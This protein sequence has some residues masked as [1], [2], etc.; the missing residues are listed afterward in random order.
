VSHRRLETIRGQDQEKEAGGA[1]YQTQGTIT[2]RIR[3]EDV[4]V[5]DLNGLDCAEARA[6]QASV[7]LPVLL[8]A[9]FRHVER[10]LC[11]LYV[12][13]KE[14]RQLQLREEA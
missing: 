10:I 8:T 14:R 5:Q 12:H 13:Q 4:A 6:A 1:D 3:K 7:P 9:D 11:D 2:G